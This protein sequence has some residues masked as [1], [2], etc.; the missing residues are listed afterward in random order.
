M[1][2]NSG[3]P[4]FMQPLDEKKSYHRTGRSGVDGYIDYMT[5]N[6]LYPARAIKRIFKKGTGSSTMFAHAIDPAYRIISL[7]IHLAQ[8]S[9]SSRSG[10]TR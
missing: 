5:R 3:T 9:I 1:E 4:V 10:F 8:A 2:K 6:H 7:T